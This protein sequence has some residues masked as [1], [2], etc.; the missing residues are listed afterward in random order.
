MAYVQFLCIFAPCVVGK[1]QWSNGFPMLDVVEGK[2]TFESLLSAT[3]EAFII[4]CLHNYSERWI[5]EFYNDAK[6][7]NETVSRIESVVIFIVEP[8]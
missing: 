6:E 2:R 7:Y 8:L 4:L 5:T 3:D 1:K